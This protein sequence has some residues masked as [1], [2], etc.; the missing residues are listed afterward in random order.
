MSTGSPHPAQL[1]PTG[2]S[3][4]A[5]DSVRGMRVEV[6]SSGAI[7]LR[8]P[9]S[10]RT[11]AEH[12]EITGVRLLTDLPPSEHPAARQ[13]HSDFDRTALLISLTGGRSI[14]FRLSEWLPAVQ[15]ESPHPPVDFAGFTAFARA[16]G[17]P[18]PSAPS[19]TGAGS[20]I[21][22]TDF[23]DP[24]PAPV[25]AAS[26]IS[27]LPRPP[28][29]HAASTVLAAG[30]IVGLLLGLGLGLLGLTGTVQAVLWC[31]AALSLATSVAVQSNIR[32][33][34][35]SAFRSPHP[36]ADSQ[37]ILPRPAPEFGADAVEEVFA[38]PE[39]IVVRTYPARS[40]TWIPGPVRG[41]AQALRALTDSAGVLRRLVLVDATGA[42]LWEPI[43]ELWTAPENADALLAEFARAGLEVRRGRMEEH[44]RSF[45]VDH[46]PIADAAE[47]ARS[48]AFTRGPTLMGAAIGL[49]VL[50]AVSFT[51]WSWVT[52]PLALA[53]LFGGIA[54]AR[55]DVERTRPG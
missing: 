4:A 17:H 8:T 39:W 54:L 23:A 24:A 2:L 42:E 34:N 3:G 29:S 22:D 37:R 47:I 16:L 11:L 1:V 35:R 44:P 6:D 50:A 28:A 33:R 46:G 20:P 38:S 51:V 43:V 26:M 36:P 14:A 9:D 32:H 21:P 30:G 48:S 31:A 10:E 5:V 13:H 25:P 27:P 18:L 52:I 41:G 53:A 49:A 19:T 45:T 55:T 15:W 40:E 12:P 7:L